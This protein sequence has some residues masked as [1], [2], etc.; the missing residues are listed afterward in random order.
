MNA[1]IRQTVRECELVAK[2]LAGHQVDEDQLHAITDQQLRCVVAAKR[3]LEYLRFDFSDEQLAVVAHVLMEL[4]A[5][6][7]GTPVREVVRE[8]ELLRR[9]A[10][11]VTGEVSDAG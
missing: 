7:A 1:G 2:L 5:E 4:S 10:R 3:A 8:L 11:E 9:A 6:C